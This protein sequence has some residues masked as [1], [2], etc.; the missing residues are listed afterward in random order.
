MILFSRVAI[1]T[2]G[3]AFHSYYPVGKW[4]TTR[5]LRTFPVRDIYTRIYVLN[6]FSWTLSLLGFIQD[7]KTFKTPTP[8]PPPSPTELPQS[9]IFTMVQLLN[10]YRQVCK[11]ILFRLMTTSPVTTVSCFLFTSRIFVVFFFCSWWKRLQVVSSL[12]APFVIRSWTWLQ[13]RWELSFYSYG[14]LLMWLVFD[15]CGS[16]RSLTSSMRDKRF[17]GGGDEKGN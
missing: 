1:S 9:D 17:R 13:L 15:P 5:S 4:G 7:S 14:A 8:P 2:C 6:E 10:L 12:I 11:W 3:R 16:R